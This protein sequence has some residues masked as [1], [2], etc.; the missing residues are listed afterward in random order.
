MPKSGKPFGQDANQMRTAMRRGKKAVDQDEREFSLARM[1]AAGSAGQ[2]STC[3]TPRSA[4]PDAL[5]RARVASRAPRRR[6]ATHAP[7]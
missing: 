4:R 1:I 6:P 2:S 3:S 5:P 7:R